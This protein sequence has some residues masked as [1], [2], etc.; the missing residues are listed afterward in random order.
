[1]LVRHVFKIISND[2]LSFDSV[3]SSMR[4]AFDRMSYYYTFIKSC[5][6]SQIPFSMRLT[7]LLVIL[8]LLVL[9]S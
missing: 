8:T 9:S 2:Y 4:W 1:M 3:M 6:G 7:S 5:S